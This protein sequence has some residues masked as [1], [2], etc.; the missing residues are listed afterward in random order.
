MNVVVDFEEMDLPKCIKFTGDILSLYFQAEISP[1]EGPFMGGL[2]SFDIIVGTRY[3]FDPP[4]VRCQSRIFHPNIDVAGNVCLNILRLD[5]NPVLSISAVLLGLL[6]IFLEP[7]PDE[8]LNSGVRGHNI[9][10]NFSEAGEMLLEDPNMFQQIV[11]STMR[12][13]SYKGIEYDKVVVLK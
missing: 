5:W 3:P 6:N 7:S 12:G 9:Q 1:E 10:L 2:Y 13:H 4:R 8:P 11:N